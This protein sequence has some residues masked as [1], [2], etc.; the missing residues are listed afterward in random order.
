MKSDMAAMQAEILG[1][2]KWWVLLAEAVCLLFYFRNCFKKYRE[3]RFEE[4][5][6]I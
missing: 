1:N 4:Q 5:T 2:W 3:I 6:L